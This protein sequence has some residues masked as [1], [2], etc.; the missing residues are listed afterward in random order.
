MWGWNDL[1]CAY[2]WAQCLEHGQ[3]VSLVTRSVMSYSLW[4]HGLQ[5][6]RPR[7]PSPTPRA[8]SNSR[9]SSHWCHPTISPCVV[10]FFTCL[11]PFPASGPFPMSQFFT[12]RWPKYWSFSFSISPSNEYSGLIS[13][14][15]DRFDLL[16]VQGA[17]R[18]LLQHHSS[19]ASILRQSAFFMVQLSHP[20]M[21]TGKTIVLTRWTFAGKV[22]SLLFNMLSKLVIL[23]MGFSRQEYWSGLPF[24]S[25]VDHILSE[26]STMTHLSWE[27]A[28]S[29]THSFIE[30]DKAAIY[31]IKLASFLWLW[32]SV[33]LPSNGEGYEAYGSFL[34]G[35]TDWGGNWVDWK[36]NSP[37]W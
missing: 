5:H 26:P 6:T 10:S 35:E 13:L 9:P 2:F 16:S 12:I 4:P 27:A 18:S 28:H 33:C 25:P 30:L 21:T 19:K 3:A 7:C 22:I 24:L 29:M 14:R 11:Q 15:I 23:L 17:L 20:Y 32:F 36:M 8:C 37:G 34:M 31:V 1:F